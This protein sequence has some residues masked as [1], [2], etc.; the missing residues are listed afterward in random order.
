MLPSLT[1]VI[2]RNISVTDP[3]MVQ[4]VFGEGDAAAQMYRFFALNL[5]PAL[6][7]SAKFAT[8]VPIDS[9]DDSLLIPTKLPGRKKDT[10]TLFLPDGNAKTALPSADFTLFIQDISFSGKA[11]FSS[12]FLISGGRGSFNIKPLTCRAHFALWDNKNGKAVSWGK[13][14][15]GRKMIMTKCDWVSLINDFAGKS[16]ER[17]PYKKRPQQQSTSNL[18]NYQPKMK[19]CNLKK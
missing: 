8:V 10:L 13:I 11:L 7:D 14:E 4:P 12:F 1:I 19:N 18:D 5:P 6:I 9:I 2:H 3:R 15:V 16:V 17:S